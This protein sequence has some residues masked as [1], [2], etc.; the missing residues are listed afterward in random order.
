MQK[1]PKKIRPEEIKLGN[2]DMKYWSDLIEAKKQDIKITE[3]N[4]KFYKFILHYAELEYQ[5]AEKEFIKEGK[6]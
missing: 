3:Q 6:K 4:L 1:Q 5:K 2:E